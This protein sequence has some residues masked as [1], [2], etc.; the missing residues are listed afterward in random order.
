[1]SSKSQRRHFTKIVAKG[2][3]NNNFVMIYNIYKK[4]INASPSFFDQI[5]TTAYP[6]KTG[7]KFPAD[8]PYVTR[9]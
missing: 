9:V 3:H 6:L 5:T 2:I 8:L 1:M 4:A 7:A